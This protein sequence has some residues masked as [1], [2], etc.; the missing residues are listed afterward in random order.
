[1]L[2]NTIH[3][4]RNRLAV[5]MANIEAFQDKKL[6]P[7]HA[8]LAAVLQALAEANELLAEIAN[9]STV[10]TSSA[11]ADEMNV[12]S[13]ITSE[14]LGFEASALK[15][16]IALQVHQCEHAGAECRTFTGDPLRIA[17]IVN[18]IVTN[19][20]RY[21]PAGGRIEVDCRRADGTL[22]LAIADSGPGI[23]GSDQQHIF[24]SG[25]RGS[26]AVGTD[27]SGLGLEIARRFAEEQ[28]GSV[29]VVSVPGVGTEFVIRLP[30]MSREPTIQKQADGVISL[31]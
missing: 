5:A 3:E 4:I 13:V 30:G 6:E 22:K 9:T 8:R 19:A 17:G 31:L 18:N 2:R 25:F 1:M 29:D 28:G 20:I 14:I 16:G 11:H 21:T 12:C 27:G 7:T 15:S 10:A 24:E 26:T 23:D